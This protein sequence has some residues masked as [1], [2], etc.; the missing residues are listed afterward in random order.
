MIDRAWV[1]VA[2]S[3]NSI[4][5]LALLML[6]A[7]R[8][9]AAHSLHELNRDI[10][11]RQY[12]L[13]AASPHPHVCHTC[14]ICEAHSDS[15]RMYYDC[16]VKSS[17]PSTWPHPPYVYHLSSPFR[18]ISWSLQPHCHKIVY[19]MSGFFFLKRVSDKFLKIDNSL[20]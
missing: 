20:P 12:T 17:S 18:F 14:Y 2:E 5:R 6:L 3:A 4:F 19:Y 13:F 9:L 15:R 7:G 1:D 8:L 10:H 11:S 16:V